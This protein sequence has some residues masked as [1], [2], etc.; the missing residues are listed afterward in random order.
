MVV[1]ADSPTFSTQINSVSNGYGDFGWGLFPVA[2]TF[3][4]KDYFHLFKNYKHEAL[5]YLGTGFWLS[6]IW[7]DSSYDYVTGTPSWIK[8]PYERSEMRFLGGRYFSPTAEV[9]AYLQQPIGTNPVSKSGSL[10]DLRFG[11]NTSVR[12]AMEALACSYSGTGFLFVDNNGDSKSPYGPGSFISAYPWLSDSR[13]NWVNYFYLNS[14]WNFR[15]WKAHNAYDGAYMEICLTAGPKWFFNYM[16]GTRIVL[17][18]FQRFYFY[19]EE[20]FTLLETKQENGWNWL[21]FVMG[22]SNS[23]SYIDGEA[24][25]QN[26]I[27]GYRLR[28]SASDRLWLRING[29]QFLTSDCYTYAELA[30]NNNLYFGHVVYES[31]NDSNPL[32]YNSSFSLYLHL[33]MF[34]FIKFE[35]SAGFNFSTGISGGYPSWYQGGQVTFS[36]TL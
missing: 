10:V 24:V 11:I 26:W 5:V 28:G 18:D 22:H 20:T 16:Q 7:I 12:Y 29:P 34:G 8:K 27:P 31:S 36:V 35:Y 14:Y 4:Y 17:S 25:P 30:I 13:I 9:Y 1:F 23:F 33:R 21:N 2:T 32:S 15:K 19:L 6:D 3:G